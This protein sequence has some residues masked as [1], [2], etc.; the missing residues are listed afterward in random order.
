MIPQDILRKTTEILN[1]DSSLKRYEIISDILINEFNYFLLK[2]WVSNGINYWLYC[3]NET[4]K[5]KEM[6]ENFIINDLYFYENDLNEVMKPI[7]LKVC[8]ELKIKYG[9]N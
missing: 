7:V 1:N 2:K 8:E 9:K 5:N 3:K 6:D 4:D